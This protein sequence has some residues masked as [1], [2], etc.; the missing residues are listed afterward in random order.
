MSRDGW[1]DLC[2]LEAEQERPVKMVRY[3]CLLASNTWQGFLA[4]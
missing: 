3:R 4:E 1:I 2:E